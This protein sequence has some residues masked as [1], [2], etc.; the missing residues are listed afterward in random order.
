MHPLNVELTGMGIPGGHEGWP[1]VCGGFLKGENTAWGFVTSGHTR[2]SSCL[3]EKVEWAFEEGK[4]I[5]K[6]GVPANWAV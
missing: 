2:A 1:W 3:C 4:A 6:R 5:D